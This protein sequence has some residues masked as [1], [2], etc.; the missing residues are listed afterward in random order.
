MKTTHTIRTIVL[1]MT[2]LV[3]VGGVLN[4]CEA[5]VNE[6]RE[7]PFLDTLKELELT[8]EQ[9]QKVF[10]LLRDY[11]GKYQTDQFRIKLL[12]V[13]TAEQA[14]MLEQLKSPRGSRTIPD[15][16]KADLDVVYAERPGTDSKFLSLDIYRP[17]KSPGKLPVIIMIH[18]GGWRIGDK[19]NLAVGLD[20]AKYFNRQGFVYVSINYRLTP[21]VQHPGHIIDVAEAVAWVHNH[22]KE[23]GGDP[24]SLFVMGHS[25]GAHLAA[26]VATDHRRL[27]KHDKALSIIDG[28]ILLDGAGY[29][30][31]AKLKIGNSIANSMYLSAFTKNEETQR[32]ASPIHHVQANKSI[33]PFLIIPIERR[34]DSNKMSDDLNNALLKANV[35][36]SIHVAEGKTHGSV[37]NDIGREKDK[38]TAAI[39][40]FL[41]TIMI[42]TTDVKRADDQ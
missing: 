18:G 38:P 5:Q 36:S 29:D 11:R 9:K 37:N 10:Q 26:L 13:L 34:A 22:I 1:S 2:C 15:D 21:E 25:A 3:L 40:Q 32:D 39:M 16:I 12:E 6:V 23:H 35:K 4:L 31:P 17:K 19:S 30:I 28:V 7:T 14:E 41:N 8:Q 24:E 27:K 33:P 20:K 42:E